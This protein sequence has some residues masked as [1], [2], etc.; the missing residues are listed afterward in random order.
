MSHYAFDP[1]LCARCGGRCC[2][3][4]PGVWVEP[5]R[6]LGAFAL[7][8]P[9]TPEELHER[10]A[11]LKLTWRDLGGVAVPVPQSSEDEGC[12]FLEADGCGLAE[13]ARPC[14]CLALIPDSDTLRQD[15][16]LCEMPDDFRLIQARRKWGAYW[17]GVGGR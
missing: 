11:A 2:R 15:E 6:F 3:E 7:P 13:A 16:L 12:S 17:D 8:S 4:T 10:F 1:Q 14:Q 9:G 5:H